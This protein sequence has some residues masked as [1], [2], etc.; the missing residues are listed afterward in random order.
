MSVP[1]QA[2]TC[3]STT[4]TYPVPTGKKIGFVH[5]CYTQDEV[6]GIQAT[7]YLH[8]G[9]APSSPLKIDIVDENGNFL[10]SAIALAYESGIITASIPFSLLTHPISEIKISKIYY[11]PVPVDGY[12]TFEIYEEASTASFVYTKWEWPTFE[13]TTPTVTVSAT[14]TSS[15]TPLITPTNGSGGGGNPSPTAPP[16]N[17]TTKTTTPT[18]PIGRAEYQVFLPGVSR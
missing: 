4:Q 18:I 9:E 17:P 5:S 3:P 16:S 14:A 15:T 10:V 12:E 8:I 13:P 11:W 7:I 2:Q 6:G 1:V